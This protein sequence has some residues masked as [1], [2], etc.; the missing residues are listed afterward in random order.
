M[1][2]G[3]VRVQ[4]HGFFEFF[5]GFS[6]K[7]GLPIGAAKDDAELRPVSELSDHALKN[8]FRGSNLMLLQIS[9]S[10]GIRNVIILGRD[11]VSCFQLGGRLR[12]VSEHEITLAQ[13]MMSSGALRIQ[14]QR[15]GQRLDGPFILL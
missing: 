7:S 13:H 12:K 1:R 3:K 10:Q 5:Y 4:D 11:L 2:A 14:T 6:Q 15:F 8:L 9:K